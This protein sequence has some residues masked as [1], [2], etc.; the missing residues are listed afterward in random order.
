[1]EW[2]N[3][4]WNIQKCTHQ[5]MPPSWITGLGEFLTKCGGSLIS[6]HP[7]VITKQQKKDRFIMKIA[8]ETTG[9]LPSIQRYR[10]YLQVATL[11]DV[12]KLDGYTIRV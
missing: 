10:M 1:M 3:A 12:I 7:R 11:A 9:D 6:N 8:T 2:V 4:C 5:W